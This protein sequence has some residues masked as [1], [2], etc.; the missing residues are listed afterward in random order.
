MRRLT[1]SSLEFCFLLPV[2]CGTLTDFRKVARLRAAKVSD[3]LLVTMIPV[4]SILRPP[5]KSYGRFS[6]EGL[7]NDIY[8]QNL[9]YDFS[10][11]TARTGGRTC[12]PLARTVQLIAV[13][14][15]RGRVLLNP[16][17][18]LPDL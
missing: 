15:I 8:H 16:P 17:F 3:A 5:L 2:F 4:A 11:G 6:S 18:S 12:G 13:S 1:N 14:V 9:L 10:L 7:L